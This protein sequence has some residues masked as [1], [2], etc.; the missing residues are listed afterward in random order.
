MMHFLFKLIKWLI[1]LV[2]FAALSLGFY[3]GNLSYEELLMRPGT[4]FLGLRIIVWI[5]EGFMGLKIGMAGRG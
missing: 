2:L 5:W 1:I 3:A 4:G